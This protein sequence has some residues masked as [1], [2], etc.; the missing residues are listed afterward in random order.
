MEEGNFKGFH[1]ID[2]VNNI[3]GKYGYKIENNYFVSNNWDFS[4]LF[5]K[6]CIFAQSVKDDRGC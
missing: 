3:M 4:P 6:N 2:N 5:Y 1:S